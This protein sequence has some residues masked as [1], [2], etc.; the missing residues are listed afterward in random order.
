MRDA[1]VALHDALAKSACRQKISLLPPD[2]LHMTVFS[3]ANDQDRTRTLWPS[4]LTLTATIEECNRVVGERMKSFHLDCEIPLRM[5]LDEVHTLGYENACSLRMVPVDEAERM[6][7]RTLRDRLADVY[8]FRATDHDR[9][10]FH[11]TVAYQ[12]A[13]FSREEDAAY[14]SLLELHVPRIAAAE[15]VLELGPP[16]FCTFKDMYR[17]DPQKILRS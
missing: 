5:R 13:P 1:I 16:E 17:F 6:K 15:P 4:D 14:T 7:L 11:I 3:G 2:S 8:L 9:Y 10:E 12:M